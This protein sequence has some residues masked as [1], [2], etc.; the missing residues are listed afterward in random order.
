V[1][2]EVSSEIQ[3][4]GAL[5]ITETTFFPAEVWETGKAH[6]AETKYL[7]YAD[8]PRLIRE[9]RGKKT[10][11]FH[12]G[13][14]TWRAAEETLHKRKDN[15]TCSRVLTDRVD[16]FG[17]TKAIAKVVCEE[18]GESIYEYTWAENLG[19]IRY[20]MGGQNKVID[21]RLVRV[22]VLIEK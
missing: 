20:S 18:G 22:D 14:D 5:L 4:S 19:Y 3:E 21:L 1:R 8:G 7:L 12:A 10:V 2:Q 11:L 16:V 6:T 15:M 9:H 17:Q 13:Q